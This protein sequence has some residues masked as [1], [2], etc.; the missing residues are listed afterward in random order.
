[1]AARW[2]RVALLVAALLLMALSLMASPLMASPVAAACPQWASEHAEKQ[3]TELGQ[4]L[5]DWNLAYRRDGSSP[6]SDDIYD[7]ARADYRQWS[8]CFPEVVDRLPSPRLGAMLLPS[9]STTLNHPVVHT[10]LNKAATDGEVA[11][12]LARHA[13]TWVQPKVDGVAVTL[14][15]RRGQLVQLISRGDG[16]TGQDWTR[17]AEVIAAV[18][19]QLDVSRFDNANAEQLV[20]QGELYQRLAGHRQQQEGTAGARSR[21]AG[22]MARE[23]LTPDI[24]RQIGLFAW[25][26]PTGPEAMDERLAGLA[27]LGFED[28]R[29]FSV[30]LEGFASAAH[31]RRQWYTSPLPFATDGVVLHAATRPSGRHWLP[32]PPDWALAWKY[33]AREVLAQVRD[34]EFSIG[35]TGRITPVAKLYPVEVDGRTLRRVGL[36]SLDHWRALD[37]LPGDQAIIETAGL[38][39]P[40]IKS[41][42][43]R[44]EP[45]YSV[46]APL[47][48]DYHPLSCWHPEPG[49]GQ[50]FL[51]RLD[52]LS[53]G[54]AL[55]LRGIGPA[56][57][58]RLVNAGLVQGLLDWRK[59]N[60][61][62]LARLTGVGQQRAQAIL[63][64]FDEAQQRSFE[65]WLIALGAPPLPNGH[66]LTTWSALQQRSAEQWKRYPGVGE[67][68]AK[69]WMQFVSDPEV[70]TLAAILADDGVVGFAPPTHTGCMEFEQCL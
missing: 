15:Y 13:P 69:R 14:V 57:W 41:V 64:S 38:I 56:T 67:V 44:G 24:G 3:L 7:Q 34:I 62:Q 39:I 5:Q 54:S 61:G 47:A 30:P 20:V 49:C 28:V 22:W 53:G 42:A 23:Q 21:V 4:R 65:Q 70:Q 35:R 52:W 63:I 18:P 17:H 59:L 11:V 12:W 32:Q 43:W 25:G 6:V 40:Q 60:A 9:L 45:R 51:A 27:Q 29:R 26:W 50:Q 66:G 16:R 10:G 33:P 19:Q 36:G 46:Q 55:Q 58:R 2:L 68:T 48:E 37:L 1:M 31:W 8:S